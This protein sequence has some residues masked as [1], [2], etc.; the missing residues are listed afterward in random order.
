MKKFTLLMLMVVGGYFTQAQYAKGDRYLGGSASIYH[1]KE[2]FGNDKRR[3][4]GFNIAPSFMKFKTE[5]FA[6]GFKVSG[7]YDNTKNES[8]A[9]TVSGNSYGIGAGIFGFH[10]LPIGKGFFL[11][12]ETGING[13]YIKGKT[14]NR[15]VNNIM[16]EASE[17]NVAGYITPSLGYKITNRLIVGVNFANLLRLGYSS[18]KQEITNF[19]TNTTTT[20]K[21]SGINLTSNFNN[22]S[23]GQLGITFGL[24]LK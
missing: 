9:G 20:A 2:E 22:T 14:D 17:V 19:A 5:K 21:R 10:V 12:A 15:P 18:G 13:G 8:V 24:K 23:V 4:I 16:F 11:A 6:L 7:I 3:S 1:S